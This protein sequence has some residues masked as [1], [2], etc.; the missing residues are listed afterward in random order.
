M[1]I[2]EAAASDASPE[3]VFLEET[4]GFETFNADKN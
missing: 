4:C 3:T 2:F 1:F